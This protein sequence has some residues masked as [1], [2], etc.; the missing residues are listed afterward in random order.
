MH[1]VRSL[2]EWS[3]Q[4]GWWYPK[5]KKKWISSRRKQSA[6][7]CTV[8]QIEVFRF[9]APVSYLN[10][11]RRHNPKDVKLNLHDREN[12]K[13]CI[14]FRSFLSILPTC[15]S[16]NSSRGIFAVSSGLWAKQFRFDGTKRSENCACIK[17]RSDQAQV[18]RSWGF[19]DGEG[20]D[21]G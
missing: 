11:T 9:V 20:L 5:R 4:T 13:T 8:L 3:V 1:K 15:P 12:L 18:F 14:L 21:V 2:K 19:H 17:K 6:E 7:K 10:T 16:W